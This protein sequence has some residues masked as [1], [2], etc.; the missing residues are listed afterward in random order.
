MR[1][2][3]P[4]AISPPLVDAFLRHR[5]RLKSQLENSLV[6]Q[7]GGAAGTLAALGDRGAQVA[8][9]LAEE[10][11]LPLPRIPWHSQRE[12]I[13]EAAAALGLLSGTM[14]KIARDLSLYM[15]TEVGELS[16]PPSTGR[17]GSSTMPHKQILSL[18]C[19]SRRYHARAGARQY[20]PRRTFREYQ[21]SLGA[22]Q[23]EWKSFLK[24]RD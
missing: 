7:F 22:W 5:K 12:R 9:L 16:E 10:L 18:R 19:Y 2:P 24:L 4:S 15:Q 21:R 14:S 8:K 11:A 17:G 3:R 23:S 20:C 6:L 1:C 13:A